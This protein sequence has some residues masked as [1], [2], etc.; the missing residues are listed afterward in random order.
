[1]KHKSLDFVVHLYSSLLVSA[2]IVQRLCF[3]LRTGLVLLDSGNILTNCIMLDERL[4]WGFWHF[5][6]TIIWEINSIKLVYEVLSIWKVALGFQRKSLQWGK[7]LIWS[8]HT[9]LLH[10]T[11]NLALSYV[12]LMHL[13]NHRRPRS[14]SGIRT[15]NIPP[16]G[17]LA[18]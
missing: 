18:T 12:S 6:R 11:L 4:T 8:T 7:C 5:V 3:K 13:A 14:Y 1:M 9:S 15:K 16:N 17:V 2:T 10:D